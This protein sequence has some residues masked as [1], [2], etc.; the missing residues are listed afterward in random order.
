MCVSVCVPVFLINLL[1]LF[2]LSFFL[3][4]LAFFIHLFIYLCDLLSPQVTEKK[5]EEVKEAVKALFSLIKSGK[6]AKK[7]MTRKVKCANRVSSH[8][9]LL[10]MLYVKFSGNIFFCASFFHTQI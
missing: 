8:S 7:M 10:V 2:I 5:K 9:V 4:L 1:C 3:S 6:T